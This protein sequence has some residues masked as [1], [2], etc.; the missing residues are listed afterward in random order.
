MLDPVFSLGAIDG[1]EAL[2]PKENYLGGTAIHLVFDYEPQYGERLPLYVYS[3]FVSFRID[4]LYK[5]KDSTVEQ[6][7]VI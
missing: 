2:S 5:G 6:V 7:E 1:E 3:D 4:I